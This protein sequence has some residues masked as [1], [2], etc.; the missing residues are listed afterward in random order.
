MAGLCEG[1]NEPPGSLKASK[2]MGVYSL[3]YSFRALTHERLLPAKVDCKKHRSAADMSG[4][5]TA[6]A[7]DMS[8]S[9][10]D[11]GFVCRRFRRQLNCKSVAYTKNRNVATTLKKLRYVQQVE[12]EDAGRSLNG[13]EDVRDQDQ[14]I[15]VVRM[16]Q[17]ENELLAQENIIRALHIYQQELQEMHSAIFQNDNVTTEMFDRAA[18]LHDKYVKTREDLRKE[19]LLYSQ[20]L[21]RMHHTKSEIENTNNQ[22]SQN[23]IE[24]NEN[25]T[26]DSD[27]DDNKWYCVEI[28]REIQPG[29]NVAARGC[30]SHGH[31]TSDTSQYDIPTVRVLDDS[32]FCAVDGPSTSAFG[33]P[34][35][36]SSHVRRTL[37]S[38]SP[39]SLAS[40]A[41]H[42]VTSGTLNT[43]ASDASHRVRHATPDTVISNTS[44]RAR[45]G[46]PE[47][48]SDASYRV[49]ADTPEA[50]NASHRVR[51]DSP[52]FFIVRPRESSF[53][54]FH[55]IT[56]NRGYLA[57][58]RD[59]G[60]NSAEMSQRSSTESYPAFAHIGKTP[61]K[62]LNQVSFPNRE[63]NPSHLVSR[64]D[65]LTVISQ[66]WTGLSIT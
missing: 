14:E 41:A 32:D 52:G 22:T 24:I 47:T 56:P 7:V 23:R 64:P 33:A 36:R 38:G 19:E 62:N 63:S 2:S 65:A 61:G 49:R 18:R 1:G 27:T 60:D 15:E 26:T 51:A 16:I 34:G 25:V 31:G 12:L 58:E 66:A 28:T 6:E 37:S 5:S 54:R 11:T 3:G 46:T 48:S 17:E 10:V 50:I 55:G 4:F 43:M 9:A 8:D 13:E 42:T 21:A 45:A 20:L 59:E 57:S 30:D 39:G 44:H 40:S 35:L 53:E 29:T